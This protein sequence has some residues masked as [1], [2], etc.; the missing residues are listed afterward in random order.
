[1][2][3]RHRAGSRVRCLG[4]ESTKARQVR[5]HANDRDIRR[6]YSWVE[7]TPGQQGR[8]PTGISASVLSSNSWRVRRK[9]GPLTA[10][11]RAAQITNGAVRT[12]KVDN[13]W[14]CQREDTSAS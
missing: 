2:G 6:P 1:M 12:Q 4:L 10:A 3:K 14:Q 7:R 8:A 11:V 5:P 13:Y 9:S